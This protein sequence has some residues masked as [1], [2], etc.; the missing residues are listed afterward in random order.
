MY[1]FKR[2]PD[3][4]LHMSSNGA[5]ATIDPFT[6]QKVTTTS[7]TVSERPASISVQLVLMVVVWYVSAVVT[8]TSTKEVMNRMQL[9][10]LLCLSQFAFAS[11]LSFV[12]LHFTSS[13]KSVPSSARSIVLQI[14]ISYTLG[15]V[16]TNIA[17]SLGTA[18]SVE[19]IKAGEPLTT[20]LLGL[21]LLKESYSS[22]TYLSLL[23]ICGGVAL[24]CYNND[25]FHAW[26]FALAMASN[27]CFS[28][29]SVYTKVL[30]A[31]NVSGFDEVNLFYAISWR[32]LVFLLPVTL[33]MEG[34]TVLEIAFGNKGGIIG[35]GDVSSSSNFA[36]IAL[37]LMLNG[38]MF[39]FYNLASYAVLKRTELVTHSVLNVFRRVFIIAF[40]SVYF[41]VPLTVYSIVGVGLATMGVLLFS[42]SRKA[43]KGAAKE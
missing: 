33:L 1:A 2:K 40:T 29:R 28:A 10:F 16:L 35:M 34:R 41:H 37:L 30:N 21:L 31:S 25:Y 5:S 23:P 43:A 13:L 3:T 18:S 17:F 9:P 11:I 26:S 6:A 39:A 4:S 22:S 20:V 12:Y 24:A 19:T 42:T 27:F 8:I 36:I 32:G 7:E 14:A 15:F 38:A